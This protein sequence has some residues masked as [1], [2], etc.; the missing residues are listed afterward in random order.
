M[1]KELLEQEF[2]NGLWHKDIAKKYGVN[3]RTIYEY[4][5]KWNLHIPRKMLHKK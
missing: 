1:T 4:V 2:K 5:K 3:P